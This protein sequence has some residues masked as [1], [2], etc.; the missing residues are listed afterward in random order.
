M[1]VISDVNSLGY[2]IPA[3][4]SGVLMVCFILYMRWQESKQDKDR[5]EHMAKWTSMVA[6]QNNNSA[7][8]RESMQSIAA[9]HEDKLVRIMDIHQKE[10]DRQ[11]KVCER[12]TAALE[13]L[14]HNL[15]ILTRDMK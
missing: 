12:N 15:S 10:M 2:A 1:D 13:A 5:E 6:A 3:G 4:I 7:A 9:A 11:F 8:Y 14:T